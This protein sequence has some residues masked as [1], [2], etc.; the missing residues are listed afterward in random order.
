MIRNKIASLE[1]RLANLEAKLRK[2]AAI[3]VDLFHLFLKLLNKLQGSF[4]AEEE[5]NDPNAYDDS[6]WGTPYDNY[7]PTVIVRSTFKRV[8]AD[9]TSLYIEYSMV[10]ED[11]LTTYRSKG[12]KSPTL[13]IHIFKEGLDLKIETDSEPITPS[14]KNVKK[15]WGPK[16]IP[17]NFQS[18]LEEIEEDMKDLLEKEDF[19]LLKK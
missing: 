5:Y 12:E 11:P 18:V 13:Y 17:S 9:D 19:P 3:E 1:A 7:D 15:I 4:K 2:K 16:T 10:I 14:T 6:V 8:S